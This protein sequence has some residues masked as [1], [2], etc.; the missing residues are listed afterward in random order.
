MRERFTPGNAWNTA[1]KS[2]PASLPEREAPVAE[3]MEKEGANATVIFVPPQFTADAIMEAI[4]A[5]MPLI[6]CITEGV[7]TLDMVRVSALLAR[8]KSRL[9]G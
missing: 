8:S 9:I 7:P 1:P 4:T 6:V 5:G 3:A 2:S